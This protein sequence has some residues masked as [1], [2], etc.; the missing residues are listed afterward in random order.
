MAFEVG[1][2]NRC[3]SPGHTLKKG[4]N[5]S[6]RQLRNE[7]QSWEKRKDMREINC[8][9]EFSRMDPVWL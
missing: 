8:K 4:E 6:G 9:R 1:E 7:V 5:K 3:S 2:Q